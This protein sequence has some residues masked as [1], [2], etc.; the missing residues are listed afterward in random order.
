[1]QKYMQLSKIHECYE[2]VFRKRLKEWIINYLAAAFGWQ[3]CMQEQQSVAEFERKAM[4]RPDLSFCVAEKWFYIFYRTGLSN[5][6]ERLCVDDGRGSPYKIE[7][8]VSK[9]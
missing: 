6:E 1:M 4:M 9:G 2:R 7:Q 3:S 8:R 5:H